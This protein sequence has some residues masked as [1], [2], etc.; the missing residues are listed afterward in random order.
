V[1][2]DDDATLELRTRAARA[3]N[4]VAPQVRDDVLRRLTGDMPAAPVGRRARE[5]HR[6]IAADLAPMAAADADDLVL[7]N[8]LANVFGSAVEPGTLPFLRLLGLARWGE[9][10]T[11]AVRVS[12]KQAAAL[13]LSDLSDDQLTDIRAPWRAFDVVLDQ[14]MPL[15]GDAI[16]AA[17]VVVWHTPL[18]DAEAGLD[19]CDKWMLFYYL[20]S[21][22]VV[23]RGRHTPVR[24]YHEHPMFEDGGPKLIDARPPSEAEM[25]AAA[26]VSR[27]VLNVAVALD[28]PRRPQAGA[29]PSVAAGSKAEK[30]APPPLPASAP[31]Q[32]QFPV[33]VDMREHVADYL[34]GDLQRVYKVRWL[35]RGHWRNQACG[36]GLGLRERIW[37]A[38][39]WKGPESP[40]TG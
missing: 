9:S 20:Q 34:S 40:A 39:H 15:G 31:V 10:G 33:Q 24:L 16:Q 23:A 21:R 36:P 32:L 8:A 35:V 37:I 17:S 5:L 28:P 18:H 2:V 29:P 30:G 19:P 7:F 13:M 25:R 27:L 4:A 11:P 1:S 14:P 3:V 38:P 6:A 26:L 22:Q 12:G